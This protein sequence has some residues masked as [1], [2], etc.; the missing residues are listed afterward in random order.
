MLP[1]IRDPGGRCLY[2]T[3]L[4]ETTKNGERKEC[5]YALHHESEA[6]EYRIRWSCASAAP[7]PT[8]QPHSLAHSYVAPPGRHTIYRL[9]NTRPRATSY[10]TVESFRNWGCT[11][12]ARHSRC[13]DTAPVTPGPDPVQCTLGICNAARWRPLPPSAREKTTIP[14]RHLWAAFA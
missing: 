3:E 13:A 12:H 7:L 8:W 9:P 14:V 10:Y 5:S 1:C 2:S 11:G 4:R 6:C